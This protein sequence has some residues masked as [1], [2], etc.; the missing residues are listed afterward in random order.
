MEQV[1]FRG[2]AALVGSGSSAS[3]ASLSRAEIMDQ[4][5]LQRELVVDDWED[6]V[7]LEQIEATG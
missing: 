1:E 5:E 6:S 4:V 3:S 7:N 2:M